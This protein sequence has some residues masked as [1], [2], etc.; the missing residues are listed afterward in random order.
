VQCLKCKTNKIQFIKTPI[1]EKV[2]NE[3]DR[4]LLAKVLHKPVRTHFKKG[5]I[6]TK[7]ID[8]LWAADLR[9]MNKIFGRE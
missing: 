7:V 6:L 8:D 4:F 5:S 2:K 1:A 9:D 3:E